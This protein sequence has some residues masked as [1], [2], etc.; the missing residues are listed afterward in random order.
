MIATGASRRKLAPS[1]IHAGN[2]TTYRVAVGEKS[3][4]LFRQNLSGAPVAPGTEVTLS[5]SSDHLVAVTP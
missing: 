5:W 1:I 3:M 4:T 2:S